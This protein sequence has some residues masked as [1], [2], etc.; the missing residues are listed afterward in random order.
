MQELKKKQKQKFS[1]FVAQYF[2]QNGLF[3][4]N[5]SSPLIYFILYS[6]LF[7]IQPRSVVQSGDVLTLKSL[8]YFHVICI[9]SLSCAFVFKLLIFVILSY[10]CLSSWWLETAVNKYTIIYIFS[11]GAAAQRGPWPP[12]S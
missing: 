3:L 1:Q 12:H 5:I 7:K 8:L 9:P 4:W 11:Y 2:T 6:Y 10:N